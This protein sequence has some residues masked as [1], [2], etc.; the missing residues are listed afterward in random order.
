MGSGAG[1]ILAGGKSTRMGEDKSKLPLHGKSLLQHMDKL[2]TDAGVET[3]YI[4][5]PDNI[6]DE[7]SGRGPLSGIH[8]ILRHVM[9]RHAHLIFVPIDMPGLTPSL[10]RQLV[11]APSHAALVHFAS[12]KMPFRLSVDKR[13]FDLAGRL[14]REEQNISLGHFQEHIGDVVTLTVDKQTEQAF[15]NINTQDEWVAFN[16]KS[17][18]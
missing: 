14:L 4:S 9:G 18:S 17:A 3:I 7:I 13:Y 10:L 6:A 12:Y 16:R 11:D 1:V 15:D 8:A 2:L 5:H